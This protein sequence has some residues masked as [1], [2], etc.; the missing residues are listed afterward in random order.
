MEKQ[1]IK[2]IVAVRLNHDEIRFLRHL[3]EG[4][5]S[6]GLRMAIERAGYETKKEHSKGFRVIREIVNFNGEQGARYT[7][8]LNNE[9]AGPPLTLS[10]SI[11][12]AL[13]ERHGEH[14]VMEDIVAKSFVKLPKEIQIDRIYDPTGKVVWSKYN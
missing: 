5:L 9:L 1:N 6:A 11:F 2:K 12:N 4:D 3:G 14:Y 10:D 8:M 13:K 7:L